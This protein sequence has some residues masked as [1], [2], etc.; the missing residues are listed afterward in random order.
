[1]LSIQCYITKV[2]V[3]KMVLKHLFRLR[4]FPEVLRNKRAEE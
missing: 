4:Q 2:K 1:M 3:L